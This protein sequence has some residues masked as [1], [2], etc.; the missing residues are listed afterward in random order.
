[1][2]IIRK[3]KNNKTLGFDIITARMLKEIPPTSIR[4][5]TIVIPVIIIFRI[6]YFSP[7][8]SWKYAQVL[9]LS[10]PWR[11]SQPTAII[12][13]DLIIANSINNS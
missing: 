4:F 10:N 11:I 3:L 7:H 8:F 6:A 5:I 13:A 1:M 9:H 2:A 12:Q